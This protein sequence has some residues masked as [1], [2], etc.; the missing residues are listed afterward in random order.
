MYGEDPEEYKVDLDRIKRYRKEYE[1]RDE[2]RLEKLR[3]QILS[4]SLGALIASVFIALIKYAPEALDFVVNI[5]TL[6]NF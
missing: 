4:Q 3:R 6:Q 1:V 5:L 2:T